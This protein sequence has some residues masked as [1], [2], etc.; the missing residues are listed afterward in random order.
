MLMSSLANRYAHQL[1]EA[2]AYS[3]SL[4]PIS[5]VST[6]S[7]TDAYD[8]AK[9]LDDIRIAE[10]ERTIGRKLALGKRQFWQDQNTQDIHQRL[11]FT[12]LFSSTVRA[13]DDSIAIQSL[14]GAREPKIEPLVV[15]KLARTPASNAT[16]DELS[17]CLEWMAHGLEIVVNAYN[18][19]T[20]DIADAIAAFGMHGTLLIG[21][22]HILSNSTRHQLGDILADASISLSCDERLLGA[23][24]GSNVML[25]PLNALWH[26]HQLINSQTRFPP[27]HAGEIISSGSWTTAYPILP[28][29]TWTTAFSGIGLAGLS[30]S[31]V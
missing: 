5:S 28:G 17:D 26:L 4:A 23:G 8:I 15:F 12:T 1:L 2:R 30:V 21:E 9:R 13:L 16:L 25:N 19:S 7:I 24:Y 31:F 14:A 3:R 11:M 6:L 10:G 27:L 22:P 20:F 29:Q 18:D